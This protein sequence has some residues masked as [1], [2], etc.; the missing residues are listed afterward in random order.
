MLAK[1]S[2]AEASILRL[3]FSA[4]ALMSFFKSDELTI[5]EVLTFIFSMFP[6]FVA[7]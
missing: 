7:V 3:N 6:L 5:L 2:A 4:S 1:I